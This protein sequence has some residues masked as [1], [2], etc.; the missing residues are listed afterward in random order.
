MKTLTAQELTEINGGSTF[1]GNISLTSSTDSLLSLTIES[2]Y[3]NR[4]E[5]TTIA[6]G[7]D[8]DLSLLAGINNQ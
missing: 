2:T 7:N 4:H 5:K 8:I 1:V 6:V 3:G